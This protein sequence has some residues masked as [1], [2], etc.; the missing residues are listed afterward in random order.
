LI[1]AIRSRKARKD[2][3]SLA[4]ES[5]NKTAIKLSGTDKTSHYSQVLSA[6]G[7]KCN[8]HQKGSEEWRLNPNKLFFYFDNI[9]NVFPAGLVVIY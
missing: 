4:I 7:E 1:D 3:I 8:H 6:I 5:A 2:F 9:S